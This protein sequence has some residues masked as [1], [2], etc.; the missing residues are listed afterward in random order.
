[1]LLH[2][3]NKTCNFS[4]KYYSIVMQTCIIFPISTDILHSNRLFLFTTS[5]KLIGENKDNNLCN[6]VAYEL[7]CI[8]CERLM[9]PGAVS[10]QI[11]E[12]HINVIKAPL[13]V[14]PTTDGLLDIMIHYYGKIIL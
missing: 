14:D 4:K 5:Y 1:M 13:I 2:G 12:V 3:A 7:R 9:H 10:L 11:I 6:N 8:L